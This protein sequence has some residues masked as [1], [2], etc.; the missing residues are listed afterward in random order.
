MKKISFLATKQKQAFQ[1]IPLI[2][3]LKNNTAPKVNSLTPRLVF[4]L[5]CVTN[6]ITG[7]ITHYMFILAQILSP[8]LPWHC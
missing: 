1:T 5:W 7:Y 4:C 6:Y 2:L 8:V 3:S